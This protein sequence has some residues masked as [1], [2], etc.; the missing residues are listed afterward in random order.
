MKI[1]LFVGEIKAAKV[2]K[3][4]LLKPYFEGS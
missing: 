2:V 4:S 3:I 1:S